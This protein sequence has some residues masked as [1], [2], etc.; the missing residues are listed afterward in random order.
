MNARPFP[1]ARMTRLRRAIG[2]ALRHLGDRTLLNFC[3]LAELRFVQRLAR[4]SST[5]ITSGAT[6]WCRRTSS[7]APASWHAASSVARWR[8][9]LDWMLSGGTLA[10]LAK[11][12][13]VH[14]SRL[15]R[16]YWQ[17]VLD[18]FVLYLSKLE[19]QARGGA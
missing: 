3:E 11:E 18:Y 17:P 8:D 16:A 2:Y 15:H 1:P 6:A 10:A 4:P 19:Q 5:V 9:V 7:A 14:R 12:W 13:G